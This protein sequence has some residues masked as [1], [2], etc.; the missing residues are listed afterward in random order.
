MSTHRAV[1]PRRT[2]AWAGVL[3][4]LAGSNYCLVAGLAGVPMSCLGLATEAAAAPTGH[5]SKA[6]GDGE[7]RT[8]H[9]ATTHSGAAAG[10]GSDATELAPCCV[11][12]VSTVT[13]QVACPPADAATLATVPPMFDVPA[14]EARWSAP[15]A[16]ESPPGLRFT[17]APLRGRAPPLA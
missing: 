12:L 15:A 6:A 17:P 16:D 7:G 4:L 14:P 2:A 8:C 1:R 9:G 13:P 5:C 10:T 11:V 3:L